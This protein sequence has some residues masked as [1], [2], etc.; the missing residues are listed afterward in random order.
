MSITR[1]RDLAGCPILVAF[2]ATRVGF[3]TLF[4]FIIPRIESGVRGVEDHKILRGLADVS[5]ASFFQNL[6]ATRSKTQRLAAT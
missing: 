6:R 5:E 2:C 4:L 1:W 3:L